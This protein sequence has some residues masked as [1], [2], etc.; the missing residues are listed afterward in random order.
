MR[1]KTA[2]WTAVIGWMVLIFVLSHQPGSV[3]SGLS[4]GI[5]EFLIGFADDLLPE[6]GDGVEQVHTF[7]RKNAHFIA[8]FILGILLV[9]ALG[10]WNN[11]HFRELL[12]AFAVSAL[13][14]ASDEFHQLFIEGRSGEFR[15]VLIDSAGAAA[16]LLVYW[17]INTVAVGKKMENRKN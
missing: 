1:N 12:I 14:G 16:G 6:N 5:T 4:S 15:D 17:T 7:V 11:L 9:N 3:S 2:A 10:S 8:Y 13:Y